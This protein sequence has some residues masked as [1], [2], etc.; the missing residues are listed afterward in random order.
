MHDKY[1]NIFSN[2]DCPSD[3]LLNRYHKGELSPKEMHAI[4]KHISECEMCSDML[5]GMSMISDE[6]RTNIIVSELKTELIANLNDNKKKRLTPFYKLSIAASIIVIVGIGILITQL[7]EKPTN[8]LAILTEKSKEETQEAA[9]EEEITTKKEDISTGETLD[10]P[11][12]KVELMDKTTL[13]Y[14]SEA[15][16]I[17]QDDDEVEQKN[18]KLDEFEI[19]ELEEEADINDNIYMDVEDNESDE[20]AEIVSFYSINQP[21]GEVAKDYKAVEIDQ[22]KELNDNSVLEKESIAVNEQTIETVATKNDRSFFNRKKK[23]YKSRSAAFSVPTRSESINN[24]KV[25][26][27][28]A[29]VSNGL[30]ISNSEVTSSSD[31]NTQAEILFDD[32]NYHL[33]AEAYETILSEYPN[34]YRSLYNCGISY[35]N[36]ENYNDRIY[37][38]LILASVLSSLVAKPHN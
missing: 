17:S 24:I 27:D 21:K 1:N 16:E 2:S 15:F 19:I 34:D 9:I 33:S 11:A 36:L 4:E 30:V 31:T 38:I 29:P 28:A 12:E 25:D 10:T 3:D 14:K 35:Y 22:A 8:D 18:S 7:T 32:K 37:H 13:S 20:E 6:E 5:E 26:E 23:A